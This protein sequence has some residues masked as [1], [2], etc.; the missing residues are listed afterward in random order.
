MPPLPMSTI[1]LPPPKPELPATPSPK[2][3]KKEEPKK[4][5]TQRPARALV[6]LSVP[7]GAAV[8]VEGQPLMSTGRERSFRTPELTPGQDYVY[9]VRAVMMVAGR[10]EVETLKLTVLAGEVSRASFERL[11]AKVERPTRTITSAGR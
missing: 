2:D 8:S 7:E 10:E 1:P 9:T 6:V 11:F 5:Q 4:S 3:A